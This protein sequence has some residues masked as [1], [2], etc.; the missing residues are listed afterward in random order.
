MVITERNLLQRKA[1][2]C[3]VVWSR[4]M[5]RLQPQIEKDR[6]SSQVK[7]SAWWIVVTRVFLAAAQKQWLVVVTRGSSGSFNHRAPAHPQFFA[8]SATYSSRTESTLNFT[9]VV[10]YSATPSS[11]DKAAQDNSGLLAPDKTMSKEITPSRV[12]VQVLVS[13]QR[14]PQLARLKVNGIQSWYTRKTRLLFVPNKFITAEL[15]D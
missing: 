13:I 4:F 9:S 5:V 12:S 10:A 3:K 11:V 15:A 14:G 8:M 2:L 7:Q 1:T 6:Y